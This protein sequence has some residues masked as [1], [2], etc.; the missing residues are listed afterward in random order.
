MSQW[1]LLHFHA[2]RLLLRSSKLKNI[3]DD[4]IIFTLIFVY[5]NVE[6]YINISIKKNMQIFKANKQISQIYGTNFLTF[7]SKSE[8]LGPLGT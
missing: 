6:I 2:C 5:I 4:Y 7:S 1:F 8:I 3:T